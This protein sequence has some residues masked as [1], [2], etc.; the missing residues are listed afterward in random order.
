M[1]KTDAQEEAERRWPIHPGGVTDT[2]D[3]PSIEM[4]RAAFVA[5][6]AWRAKF[7]K[8]RKPEYAVVYE[9]V[10]P[11]SNYNGAATYTKIEDAENMLAVFAENYPDDKYII[12]KRLPSGPWTEVK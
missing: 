4:K 7:P 8:A 1:T 10:K 3:V 12:W 6:A 11:N 5:G 9:S 2:R